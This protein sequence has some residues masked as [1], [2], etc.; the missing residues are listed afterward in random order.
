MGVD[1][2]KQEHKLRKTN[3]NEVACHKSIIH[4][5]EVNIWVIQG[6]TKC[7]LPKVREINIT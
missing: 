3:K 7:M 6:Y 1:K 4:S 5:Y 2:G